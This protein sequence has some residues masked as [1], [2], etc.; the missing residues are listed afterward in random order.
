MTAA[1]FDVWRERIEKEYADEVAE[2]MRLTPE[3][4]ARKSAISFDG[5]LPD[6]VDTPNHTI[7]VVEDSDGSEVGFLWIA[8]EQMDGRNRLFVYDIEISPDERGRGLGREAMLLVEAEARAHGV[9]R[10]E[11][12]VWPSN[13]V[14]RALYRSLDFEE[15]SIGMTKLVD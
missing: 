11:L 6:G 15:T 5:Y 14:A 10:I 2:A 8:I 12:N 13:H 3:E 9:G 7:S 4:A 1:E